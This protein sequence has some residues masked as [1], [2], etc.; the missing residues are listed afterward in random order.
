MFSIGIC[1]DKEKI[2][3]TTLHRV[4]PDSMRSSNDQA[5]QQ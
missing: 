3:D 1:N 2:V 4:D 5:L